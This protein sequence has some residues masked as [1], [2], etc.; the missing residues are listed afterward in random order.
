MSP[1]TRR[2]LLVAASTVLALVV[3][4]LGVRLMR[5]VSRTQVVRLDTLRDL[6]DALVW[7][8]PDS[9]AR[10][11][12]ACR[13]KPTLA[14]F[15]SSILYGSGVRVDES[16]D[17]A[18]RTARPDLCVHNLA[19]PALDFKGKRALLHE[20][21]ADRQLDVVVW[22]VWATDIDGYTRVGDAAYRLR[23]MRLDDTGAPD[24]WGVPGNGW[25]FRHSRVWELVTLLFAPIGPY[26]PGNPW[27]DIADQV[28]VLADEVA[29]QG[30]TLHVLFMPTLEQSFAD[31]VASPTDMQQ[32]MGPVLVAP[33]HAVA[34][35]FGD[36][37]HTTVALDTCCHY[38]PDGHLVLAERIGALA[39]Q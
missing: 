23:G 33:T 36:T 28:Q 6:D 25:L 11:D 13:D 20:L 14:A 35:W 31:S 1:S 37:D 39:P 22:E 15:G 27:P 3:A 2:A 29:A 21:L 7:Q 16:W 4:E 38:N 24:A 32:A 12:L 5:P 10:Q 19:Q 17:A 8:G 9:P 18:L 34:E 26:A 30:G